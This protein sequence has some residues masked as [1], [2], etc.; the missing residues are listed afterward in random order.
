M[1]HLMADEVDEMIR[2]LGE[3]P[4]RYR[5]LPI[6]HRLRDAM[7]DQGDAQLDERGAGEVL[8]AIGDLPTKFGF[9][10]HYDALR[11]RLAQAQHQRVAVGGDN[12][13]GIVEDREQ[14]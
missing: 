8:A 4:T 6:V 12:L 14:A 10:G 13:D 7:T 2:M 9:T 1:T 5:V 3:V 11:M